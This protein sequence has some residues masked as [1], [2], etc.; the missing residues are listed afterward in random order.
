MK[1]IYDIDEKLDTLSF[2]YYDQSSSF[3]VYIHVPSEIVILPY[4]ELVFMYWDEKTN[5]WTDENLLEN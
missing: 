5:T 3:K 1:R 2:V 4:D